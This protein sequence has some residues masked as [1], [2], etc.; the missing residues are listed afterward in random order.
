MLDD[1]RIP[2]DD[3]LDI[4]VLTLFAVEAMMPLYTSAQ[5]DVLMPYVRGLAVYQVSRP[6]ARE[7]KTNVVDF[8]AAL[9]KSRLAKTVT[10]ERRSALADARNVLQYSVNEFGHC[11]YDDE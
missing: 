8:V 9:I 5:R 4:M 2:R 11:M 7:V 1:N 6:I 10:R 3:E